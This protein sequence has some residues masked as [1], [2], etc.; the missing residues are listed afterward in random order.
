M[1]N[2]RAGGSALFTEELLKKRSSLS[3]SRGTYG[4]TYYL[5]VDV[6]LSK[7]KKADYSAFIVIEKDRNHN[8]KV[9]KL[10]RY[11]GISEKEIKDRIIELHRAFKFRKILIEQKGLSYGIVKDLKDS[12]SEIRGYV[13]GF[14]T[15]KQNKE[16]LISGIH[17]ALSTGNLTLLENEILINELRSFGIKKDKRTGRE[18]Y[19]ALGGHDDT[20]I[21]LGLSVEAASGALGSVSLEI[22]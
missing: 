1:T 20:V 16:E 10:E 21:G 5:G 2:P 15:N 22:I 3:L 6:A 11:R 14:D 9:V 8:L 13:M 19:E 18:T 17:T 12:N 4:F 7:D